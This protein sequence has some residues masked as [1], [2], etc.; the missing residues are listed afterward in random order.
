MYA[1]KKNVSTVIAALS[2]AG[3][4]AVGCCDCHGGVFLWS[5]L[6]TQSGVWREND[7][8]G[9]LN[10]ECRYVWAMSWCCRLGTY[11]HTAVHAGK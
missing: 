8:N 7:E 1:G 6:A 9:G 11:R 4:G 5:R 3:S 2:R 10:S